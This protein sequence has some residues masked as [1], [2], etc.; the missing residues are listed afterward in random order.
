MRGL[1]G[2]GLAEGTR[3]LATMPPGTT[4]CTWSVPA[5]SPCS[6]HSGPRAG[7]GGGG[8][9]GGGSGALEGYQ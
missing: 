8:G 7:G 5:I 2:A 6:G 1:A 3:V 9:G 4:C